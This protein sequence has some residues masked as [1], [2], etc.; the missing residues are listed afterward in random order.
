MSE[1]STMIAGRF[2]REE[3]AA[4]VA[5]SGGPPLAI[6]ERIPGGESGAWYATD[7][8]DGEFVLKILT[9]QD[10]TE[11]ISFQVAHLPTLASRGYPV[12]EIT[13]YGPLDDSASYLLYPFIPSKP[14][15]TIDKSL[16]ADIFDLVELQAN[17]NIDAPKRNWSLWMQGVLF[18]DWEDWW[19]L[20]SL[21][22]RQAQK[23][24][25]TLKAWVEPAKGQPVPSGDFYP[26]QLS[27]GERTPKRTDNRDC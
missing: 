5:A 7:G 10:H 26:R 17:A 27:P 12:P 3:I 20:V 18:E 8:R 14:A 16:L 6:G 13:G 1:S 4:T 9:G 19:G 23:L 25:E 11:R 15:E 22:S 2:S 24:C 21:T